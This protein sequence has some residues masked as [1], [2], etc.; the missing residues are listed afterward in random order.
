MMLRVGEVVID[1]AEH[2]AVVD[3]WQAALDYDRQDV[4]EQYVGLAPRDK[5]PGRPPILFQKVPEA[6]TVRTGSTWTSG[7]SPW[8][9]RSPG[10]RASARRSSRSGPSARSRG[11]CWP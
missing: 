7:P 5:E 4:N 10:S 1:C 9:T 3:F 8:R 2:G 6:K 11:P